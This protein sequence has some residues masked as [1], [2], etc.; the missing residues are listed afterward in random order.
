MKKIFL[1]IILII[2][3]FNLTGCFGPGMNDYTYEMVNNYKVSKG[4][5]NGIVI[6]K[7][8]YDF[9]IDYKVPEK[10][11]KIAWDDNFILAEQTPL[12][13]NTQELDETKLYFWIINSI[14]DDVYGPLSK[15]EFDSK[16][17]ELSIDPSLKLEDPENFK[18][19][20]DEQNK[21]KK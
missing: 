12:I 7:D 20:R 18:Y 17:D 4:S 1:I 6:Y 16:C 13:K 9:G 10:V 21:S 8:D 3:T 5:A 14:T 11:T 15:E 2:F 19:L